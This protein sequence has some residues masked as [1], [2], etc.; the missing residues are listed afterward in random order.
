MNVATNGFCIQIRI[1]AS[2]GGT[3]SRTD[4]TVAS[5]SV[6]RNL[7][8]PRFEPSQYQTRIL[9]TL[10]IGEIVTTVSAKDNDRRVSDK[11]NL[12]HFLKHIV[13]YFGVSISSQEVN[14]SFLSHV[15]A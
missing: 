10:T 5:V 3:P 11:Y 12:L 2:D 4:T 15:A 13:H 9:E 8:K 1:V 7:N 6:N 14:L